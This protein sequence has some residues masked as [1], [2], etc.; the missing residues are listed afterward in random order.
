MPSGQWICVGNNEIHLFKDTKKSTCFW[1]VYLKTYIA[2]GM[3]MQY[4]FPIF[5]VFVNLVYV[6]ASA[7][8][9]GVNREHI[10]W[11]EIDR[12]AMRNLIYPTNSINSTVT[13]KITHTHTMRYIRHQN[14]LEIVYCQSARRFFT[15]EL[16]QSIHSSS[17][18]N[19]DKRWNPNT[20]DKPNYKFDH[21]AQ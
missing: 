1:S 16:K 14:S 21:T 6:C 11:N 20:N 4:E 10:K 15:I 3:L 12:C 7:C 18:S 8:V 13:W 19:N 2:N 9:V 5:S 17:S